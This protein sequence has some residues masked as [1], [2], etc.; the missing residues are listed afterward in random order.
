MRRKIQLMAGLLAVVL[1]ATACSQQGASTEGSPSA[2]PP[3]RGGQITV[4][5]DAS[6]DGSWPSGLD[7]ATNTTGGANIA[8][9]A[10]I[11]GGLF[12]ISANPDGTGAKVVPH[13]AESY[14]ILDGGRPS[15][16]RSGRASRSP[17]APRS[18]PRRCGS[19]STAT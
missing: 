3:Q 4:L 14:Q 2:G 7:P 18:T 9:M 1:A 12:V 11:Y 16:S 10:A 19:T 5:K 8:Q 15:R 13:Q 17:T 6:F